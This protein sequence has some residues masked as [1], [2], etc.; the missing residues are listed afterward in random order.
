MEQNYKE[1][2][3]DQGINKIEKEIANY[4][5]PIQ[6]KGIVEE[7]NESGLKSALMQYNKFVNNALN[8]ICKDKEGKI[9][10]LN[11]DHTYT[12][13]AKDNNDHSFVHPMTKNHIK[14]IIDNQSKSIDI[15]STHNTHQYIILD[16]IMKGTTELKID[17]DNDGISIQ[18]F[19]KSIDDIAK[20]TGKTLINLTL[21]YH[22]DEYRIARQKIFDDGGTISIDKEFTIEKDVTEKMK[23]IILQLYDNLLKKFPN[24]T[25]INL[26]L[27]IEKETIAEIPSIKEKIAKFNECLKKRKQ[28]LLVS[29]AMK[30]KL[31]NFQRKDLIVKD[32]LCVDKEKKQNLNNQ[33]QPNN[34]QQ[35]NQFT[36]AQKNGG[37]K[38]N[39]IYK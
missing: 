28:N 8:K 14:M 15:K 9:T 2:K 16:D 5:G 7:N 23:P 36:N 18:D 3:M 34:N 35:Q 26:D 19:E 29:L 6:L 13:T 1:I 25:N 24:A 17:L 37:D 39:I 12:Y 27:D 4:N 10:S 21:K 20:Q 38:Q 11:I 33:Q 22:P 30:Q 32:I 31:K